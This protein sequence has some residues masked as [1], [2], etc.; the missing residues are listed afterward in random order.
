MRTAKES[1]LERCRKYRRD[2]TKQC[3]V[4]YLQKVSI[5]IIYYIYKACV[6][7]FLSNFHFSP[8]DIP[9]K[10]I[11]VFYFIKEALLILKI[12][13]FLYFHLPLFFPVSHCVR[14]WSKKNL[15][16]YDVINCLNENLITHFVLYLEKEIRCD[17]ETLS[18]DRE[19][20]KEHFNRKI[21][22]KMCLK[23]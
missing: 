8:N 12:L 2:C 20:N 17:I 22:Q 16:N 10:T 3:T 1:E 14:G 11:N 13:K 15:K 19:L 6:C 18:I 9:S 23:T 7:Y 21:M 4:N 5:C